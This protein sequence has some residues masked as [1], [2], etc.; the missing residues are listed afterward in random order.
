MV[1]VGANWDQSV[2]PLSVPQLLRLH[3]KVN[4]SL[5]CKVE[6]FPCSASSAA[7]P[8]R[9]FDRTGVPKPVWPK[10]SAVCRPG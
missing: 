3:C 7:Q 6:V 8:L 9:E 4:G 1:S 10:P 2:V 5:S